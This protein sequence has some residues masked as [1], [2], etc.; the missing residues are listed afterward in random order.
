MTNT[1]QNNFLDV[2]IMVQPTP[3]PNAFKFIINREVKSKGKTTYNKREECK[4]NPLADALFGIEHVTQLHFFE[5]VITVTF[6]DQVNLL[7]AEGEVQNIIKDKIIG[8]DPNFIEEFE[9]QVSREHLSPDLQQIEDI[10]DRT[11]RPGLQGDGGDIAVLS[12]ID[13]ELAIRYQGACGTCPSSTAGTLMA[14]EGILKSEF[15]PDIRV[16]PV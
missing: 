14:I 2:R 11:I 3:N 7:K 10:L 6:S 1:A 4:N 13:N 9:A 16:I 12:L 8:H 5:N 15:D